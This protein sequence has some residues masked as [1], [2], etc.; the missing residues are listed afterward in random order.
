MTQRRIAVLFPAFFGGGAEFVTAWMLESLKNDNRVSLY[1]FSDINFTE[2]N[3]RFGTTLGN[4][5]IDLHVIYPSLGFLSDPQSYYMMTIRQHLLASYFRRNCLD[6]DLSIAAFNEM[7]LGRPGIQYIH[8]PLFGHG[9]EK[10]RRILKYPTSPI[11]TLYQRTFEILTGYS[12]ERMKGNLTLTNSHWTADLIKDSYGINAQILHPLVFLKPSEILW[13]NRE[14][15]FIISGRLTPDK[16][17]ETAIEIISRVRQEQHE[18]H[19]HIVSGGYDSQ[20]RKKIM[21]LRD[22]NAQWVFLHENLDR[23]EFSRLLSQHRYGIHARANETFGISIA[24]MVCSGIVPFIPSNGGQIEITGN[25]PALQFDTIDEAV[26]K[27]ILVLHSPT[28]QEELLIRLAARRKL[29]T[30]DTFR[31]KF[32]LYIDQVINWF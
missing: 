22:Q 24:E 3:F 12:D 8:V 5:D 13:D 16:R 27:I 15:G 23:A 9:N 6:F 29:F 11:R 18:V 32:R 10:A 25:I 4:E 1:T 14:N 20:Y 31:E 30:P 21:E 26:K 19:L 28:Q 2:I 7:D 17:I